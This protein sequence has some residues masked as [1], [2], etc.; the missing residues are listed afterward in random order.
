VALL[1]LVAVCVLAQKPEKPR[2][3]GLYATFDTELGPFVAQLFEKDTPNSVATF[4]G[5]AQGVI[6]WRDPKSKQMVKRPMYNDTTFYRI[7]PGMAIQGGSPS[8][9]AAFDC[10]FTIKDEIL[11]GLRFSTGG[12]LAMA[13]AGPD[14]GGCQFFVTVGPVQSWDNNYT[15]F[16]QVIEGMPVVAAINHVQVKGDQPLKPVKLNKVTIERVGTAPEIKKKK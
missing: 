16:G 7:L 15:I 14:T 9:S 3:D 1:F 5:L 12:K 6:P 11:P 4:I 8:G 10:G 2:K 13:N